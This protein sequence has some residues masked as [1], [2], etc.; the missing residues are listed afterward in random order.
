MIASSVVGLLLCLRRGGS[1]LPSQ[2]VPAGTVDLSFESQRPSKSVLAPVLPQTP[3]HAFRAARALFLE[4]RRPRCRGQEE[5]PRVCSSAC[6]TVRQGKAPR[7]VVVKGPSMIGLAPSS[8]P[9]TLSQHRPGS[10]QMICLRFD[11]TLET[12]RGEGEDRIS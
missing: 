5:P 9:Y 8:L 6:V 12:F 2:K 10:W 3:A 7:V 4:S 1:A 11:S